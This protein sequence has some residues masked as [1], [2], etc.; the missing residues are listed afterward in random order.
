V[1]K[2]VLLRDGHLEEFYRFHIRANSFNSCSREKI[3]VINFVDFST[4]RQS[5]NEFGSVQALNE[6]F[7]FVNNIRLIRSIRVRYD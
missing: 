1:N 5:S 4:A 6:K 2:T 7:V 3:R